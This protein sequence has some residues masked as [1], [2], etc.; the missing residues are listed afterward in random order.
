MATVRTCWDRIRV[1]R[2]AHTPCAAGVVAAHGAHES[3]ENAVCGRYERV[4]EEVENEAAKCPERSAE[5]AY[6]PDT[7]P[8]RFCP[9]RAD[10][11]QCGSQCDQQREHDNRAGH[12]E[13]T[14]KGD[15]DSGREKYR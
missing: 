1:L 7:E 5:T 14:I 15:D 4:L 6:P 12:I 8:S 9:S 2:S 13:H 10:H 11:R 3:Q